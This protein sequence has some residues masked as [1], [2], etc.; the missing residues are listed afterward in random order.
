[1]IDPYP[2]EWP[3]IIPKN[4]GMYAMRFVPRDNPSDVFTLIVKW[5]GENWL[6]EKFG[7]S[8]LRSIA[9]HY[10]PMSQLSKTAEELSE[11]TSAVMRYSQRP[12]KLHFKQM[13]EEFADT[14]IMIEQ[15]EL[16]FPELAEEIGKCQVLKVDRQLDRIEE[17]ELLK[18]WRD[19]E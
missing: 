7:A 17:E 12:T 11:A 6:D 19:E 9:E 3:L 14:L 16:L 10:G 1:M 2:Y 5:D 18:K 13:A 8:K 4:V 15:L